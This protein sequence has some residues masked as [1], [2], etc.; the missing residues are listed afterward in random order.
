MDASCS[1]GRAHEVEALSRWS[2]RRAALAQ[3]MGTAVEK[4]RLVSS[5]GVFLQTSLQS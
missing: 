3:G 4:T 2:L 1:D 5:G